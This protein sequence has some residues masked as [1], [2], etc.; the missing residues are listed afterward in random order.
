M[1]RGREEE[2]DKIVSGIEQQIK[3][4]LQKKGKEAKLHQPEGD[5]LKI[6]VRDHTPWRDIFGNMLVDSRER[7]ILGL[8][9]M[10]AQAFFFNA[11][12]FT[13]GLVVKKFFGVPDNQ[14]PCN[15]SPSPSAA[16]SAP[17]S[18]APS[19]TVSAASP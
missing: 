12:F 2:A 16:F 1:L 19:S 15:C 8:V 10:I 13:Y 9:L 17:S 3:Q 5:K 18:S 4:T 11:V 6:T 14:L 7:S